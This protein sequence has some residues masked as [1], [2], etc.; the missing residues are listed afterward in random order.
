MF[1]NV[2]QWPGN[3]MGYRGRA[4]IMTPTLDFLASN[5][6]A[7]EN[8]YSECPVCI[9][10]RRTLMTGLSPRRHGDR[11]YSDTMRMPD[12]VTLAQAFSD[13]G[14]QCVATG[15]LHVYPQRSRIGFDEV[16]LLEEGRSEFGVT[17]D[18]EIWLAEHGKPGRQFLHAMGNNT[19]Y[20]RPWHLDEESHDTTWLTEQMMRQIARRDPDRPFFF[21]LSYPGPHP[22]LVPLKTFWD[23]YSDVVLSDPLEDD[24]KDAWVLD[25]FRKIAAPYSQKERQDARRAFHAQCTHIDYSIRLVLGALRE[26]GVLEDTIIVFASD[27]GDMLF[28]HG[29]VAKRLMYE[30]S[31]SVPLIF[32]GYPMLEYRDRGYEKKLC[33][34]ADVMPSLLDLCGIPAPQDIDGISVFSEKKHDWIYGEISEGNLATRMIRRGKWKLIW[35]PAGNVFQLFDLEKDR[36]EYH[37][38]SSDP[39]CSEVLSELKELLVSSLYGDDLEWVDNGVLK[40]F[41]PDKKPGRPNFGLLNQRGSHWPPPETGYS[42]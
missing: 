18:Y 25:E 40:G 23:K 33:T 21:Y 24:W 39:S 14:Y 7:M 28:D 36:N 37:D 42:H 17:D 9:P 5:G 29:M 34:L 38:L 26:H 31:A 1:I 2:D 32:S 10:A 15:K 20:T 16:I 41:A 30:S 13:A 6:I 35:Y 3:L 4:D 8:A 12:A 19:Y 11:V 27:H 22:P